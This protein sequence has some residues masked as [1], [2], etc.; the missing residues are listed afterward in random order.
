MRK[1]YYKDLLTYKNP[2]K[3]WK[4]DGQKKNNHLGEEE[5]VNVEFFNALEGVDPEILD[6]I[7]QRLYKMKEACEKRLV[8]HIKFQE[9]LLKKIYAMNKL[10]PS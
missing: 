10:S 1:N 6:I 2:S 7:N 8:D 9:E 4:N 3:N 5:S